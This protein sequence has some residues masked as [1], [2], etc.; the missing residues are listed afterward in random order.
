MILAIDEVV[1]TVD[2]GL[3]IWSAVCQH[4]ALALMLAV[5]DKLAGR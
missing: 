3:A 1:P 5:A 4:T 2:P